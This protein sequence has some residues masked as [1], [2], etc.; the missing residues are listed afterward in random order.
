MRREKRIPGRNWV[1]VLL[2]WMY[3]YMSYELV[4]QVVGGRAVD[5]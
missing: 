4:G 3:K 1:S 2:E 5:V